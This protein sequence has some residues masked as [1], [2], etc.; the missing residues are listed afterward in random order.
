MV[1]MCMVGRSRLAPRDTVVPR[2]RLWLGTPAEYSG[3]QRLKL[4][5]PSGSSGNPSPRAI[6]RPDIRAM[7]G[8]PGLFSQAAACGLSGLSGGK[9]CGKGKSSGK[10]GF[11]IEQQPLTALGLLQ[12]FGHSA[13]FQFLRLHRQRRI[14]ELLTIQWPVIQ[15]GSDDLAVDLWQE[16][17][18]LLE[19]DSYAITDLLLLVHQGLPG[20]SEANEI[21]WKLLH[22]VGLSDDLRDLSRKASSMI[23]EGRRWIDRPPPNSRDQAFWNWRQVVQPRNPRWSPASVPASPVVLTKPDGSPLPPPQRWRP[24][25]PPKAPPPPHVTPEHAHAAVPSG[26]PGQ[27]SGSSNAPQWP[28]GGGRPAFW[29]R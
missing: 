17:V 19:L 16:A 26:P 21:M 18:E 12:E 7:S 2:Q 10:F 20:R 14:T 4:R 25:S 3:A 24:P 22:D 8:G 23:R 15:G 5:A 11:T 28:S 29:R 1:V 6:T 9:S 13:E 27:V